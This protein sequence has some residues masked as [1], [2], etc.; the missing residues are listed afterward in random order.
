MIK[1]I[2]GKKIS[3]K[4]F[5]DLAKRTKKLK[6]KPTLAVILIGS[7]KA[8]HLYVSIKEKRAVEIGINFKKFIL[9]TK[10]KQ[11]E[12]INLIKKLNLNQS[13][14]AILIQ[15]PLP[16]HLNT[17]KIINSVDPR[18]DADG[19]HPDSKVLPATTGAIIEALKY[20]KA[21]LK[22]KSV[23]IIGK[24]KIV[25]LPTFKYLKDK[26][27]KINIYDSKTKNL[28]A[29]CSKA[30]I[31]IV[32]IGKANLIDHKYIKPSAIVI[33]VGINKLKGKTVGD[34]DFNSTESIASYITPVPGGI[35]PITVAAL[36]SNTIKLNNK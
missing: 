21:N 30:D 1:L 16:K 27:K 33:D 3:H 32:A 23:A 7:D 18:K 31:L 8:S 5:R 17:D 25:G 29:E 26:A 4:I 20:T 11:T 35:G 22:N 10:T 15:L 12:V 24:S 6:T 36:L 9:P 19:I 34:V 13:I 28:P 14:T 2:D